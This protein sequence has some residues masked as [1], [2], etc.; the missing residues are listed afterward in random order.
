[1]AG[2]P[3]A[4]AAPVTPTTMRTTRIFPGESLMKRTMAI[5]AAA[6]FVLAAGSVFAH[7]GHPNLNHANEK[8]EQARTDITKA[9]TA[10]EFDLGGHAAKAKEL[11]DQA[12]AEL[13][14]ARTDAGKDKEK[15]KPQTP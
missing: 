1:M 8:L 5:S 9:Q 14:Q 7:G 3:V 2:I 10:N 11:L 13:Q 15:G 4:M 12:Y 6:L